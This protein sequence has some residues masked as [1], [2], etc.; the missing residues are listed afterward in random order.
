MTLPG[1]LVFAFAELFG[2]DQNLRSQARA[3]G[4]AAADLNV[5]VGGLPPETASVLAGLHGLRGRLQ[6][7]QDALI[8][9]GAELGS[10]GADAQRV[11]AGW[12][13]LMWQ[14]LRATVIPPGDPGPLGPTPWWVQRLG[15]GGGALMT[16]LRTRYGTPLWVTEGPKWRTYGSGP[17][18]H[19]QLQ[20]LAD[21]LDG[22]LKW[23]GFAAGAAGAFSRRLDQGASV[24]EATGGAVGESGTMFAC[25]TGAARGAMAAPI[26]HPLA[27]GGAVLGAG[28]IGG[29]ACSGPGRWVGDRFSD[30]VEFIEDNVDITPWDGAVPDLGFQAEDLVPDVDLSG[31]GGFVP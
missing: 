20:R 11:D 9:A 15:L 22:P 24:P 6:S 13:G 10:L 8:A 29:A 18:L 1:V 14:T 12:L 17:R 27:K 30:G 21:K 16:F 23:G 19:P 3:V 5:D 4:E 2:A 7:A 25:A 28:I 31:L 26:P